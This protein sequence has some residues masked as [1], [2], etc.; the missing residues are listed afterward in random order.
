MIK[1]CPRCGAKFE[2]CVDSDMS[3]CHC[4]TVSLTEAQRYAL[5]TQYNDCLCHECLLSFTRL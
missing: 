3:H 1:I 5:K 4:T 2:C